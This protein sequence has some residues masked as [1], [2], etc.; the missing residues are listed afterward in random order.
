MV[1][2]RVFARRLAPVVFLIGCLATLE[3]A[4]GPPSQAARASNDLAATGLSVE[5]FVNPLG[6]DSR[7][8]RFGWRLETSARATVQAAYQIQV[9]ENIEQLRRGR[10]LLWDTGRI[11]TGESTQR[12]YEGRALASRTRYFWRVRVWDAGGRASPWSEPAWWETGLLDPT[13]WTARWIGPAWD[14][15]TS[16]PQPS[17]LL[18]RE[19]AVRGRVRSARAYVTSQGL[20]ELHL[21]GRRVGDRLF[22]P[23]WTSYGKRIQY[24][25]YDVTEL[26]RPGGNAV[27]AILG[28]GWF[29]G[30]VGW[31]RKRNVYGSRLALLLQIEIRY[32]D[33]RAETV[34]SDDQWKASTG[35]IVA[36]DI[37]DGETYDATR[38]MPGWAAA[39][40]DDRTWTRVTVRASAPPVVL[41]ASP[42]P[43][44]VRTEEVK[45]IAILDTPAGET[46]FDFGQIMTGFVRLAVKG[47]A[48][49]TVTLRHAEILDQKGN[50]YTANLRGADQTDRYTLRGDEAGEVFE[51][52]F[53]FHG[54]RYVALSGYPGTPTLDTLTGIV[55]HSNAARTGRLETSNGRLNRLQQNIVWSQRGNFLDVPTDC[56]Q[57]DERLGWTGDAQVFAR[58]AAFNMGVAG[59]F[60]KWLR[61]LASDQR[62]SG[63]VPHVVPDALGGDGDA[64]AGAVGW[65][66][67][68]VVVPWT[69]YRVYGDRRV[70][71]E[72]YPSMKAW[73]DYGLGQAGPGLIW[74][75]G[76]QFG[77]WLSYRGEDANMAEPVTDPDF[78]AT[79]YLAHSAGL[80]ARAA[81]VIGQVE[82]AARYEELVGS[83]RRAF[84]REFVTEAGR[85]GDDTQ[86]AYVLA[87]AFGLL[88]AALEA[89]AVSRLV[90]DIE[91]HKTHLTTG[92]LGTPE[93]A[94]VLTR[95]GRLDV[96]YALLYQD[97]YPSWLYPLTRG[98]TTIWERWDGIRPSGAFQ[99]PGMNSFNHYAYGAIGDWMYRVIGGID[100]DDEVPGY[101]RIRLRPRPGGDLTFARAELDTLYGRVVCAWALDEGR[102]TMTIDVPPNASAEVTLPRATLAE[103][104]ETGR[105]LAEASGVTSPRQTADGVTLDVGS[106][107]YAF[108]APYR[109]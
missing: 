46:V 18:R 91:R 13:D 66:D 102:F 82:D 78:L 47:P 59:F 53:T 7:V 100:L 35:P 104:T 1:T 87:L 16:V 89:E 39:G 77:D 62:P 67:A 51:P 58:T 27:G 28:D 65:G 92:F 21:N 49:T 50:L 26:L 30:D 69:V 19:F 63:A 32:E 101:K 12:E 86:T 76:S 33:G 60:T 94:H 75:T 29:R 105:P 15:D 73:V 9:S 36:S 90:I 103:V 95:Y 45:P 68:A 22:T 55:V 44:V 108:A 8:P 6:V 99:D 2:V 96:A 43:P 48:K 54:F 71:A 64:N 38:E 106:G 34:A 42:A 80:M 107:H 41:A 70:L 97:T 72:Q 61:D 74:R 37:Y 84:Q 11:A 83:I 79:A 109:R 10:T 40:F 88:P 93:L 23:G 81:R 14:E 17:P 56:P 25:T 98:A 24:Q 31:G 57:R 20:Y 3:G 85:V 5:Y 52:R 4:A